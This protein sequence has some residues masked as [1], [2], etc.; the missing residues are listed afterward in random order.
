[1]AGLIVA[2]SGSALHEHLAVVK[3]VVSHR[4]CILADGRRVAIIVMT[5]YGYL[6]RQDAVTTAVWDSGIEVDDI[7]IEREEGV[8]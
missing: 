8:A 3:G 1:M 6:F 4:V 2:S 5:P 7:I